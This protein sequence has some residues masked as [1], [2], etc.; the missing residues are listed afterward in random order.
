MSLA[1][2]QKPVEASEMLGP[3]KLQCILGLVTRKKTTTSPPT[4]NLT[5][6]RVAINAGNYDHR[7]AN[8]GQIQLRWIWLE[9]QI[10]LPQNRNQPNI[11]TNNTQAKRWWTQQ[12]E[13]SLTV[14]NR[15]RAT[16]IQQGQQ[17]KTEL[18]PGYQS[19]K[20]HKTIKWS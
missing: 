2:W 5:K 10:R 3:G 13:V 18:E 7:N 20:V 15:K 17:F 9:E 4:K 6:E 12:Q 14:D 11:M 19:P 1:G 8:W 16:T